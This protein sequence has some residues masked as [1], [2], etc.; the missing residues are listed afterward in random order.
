MDRGKLLAL[1][2]GENPTPFLSDLKLKNYIFDSFYENYLLYG[3]TRRCSVSQGL[4]CDFLAM[5]ILAYAHKRIFTYGKL[6]VLECVN[7]YTPFK[8]RFG[9]IFSTLNINEVCLMLK[10]NV[11]V[12]L[13]PV[14]SKNESSYRP[15]ICTSSTYWLEKHLTNNL[16][17]SIK[18]TRNICKESTIV[19]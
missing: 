6:H 3:G 10:D 14:L 13:D 2:R 11:F 15:L 19:K 8:C 4:L 17:S 16:R 12:I 5:Q 18:A 9:G 1:R 7:K